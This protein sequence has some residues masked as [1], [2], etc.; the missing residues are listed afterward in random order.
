[1][2]ILDKMKKTKAEEKATETK[3]PVK[4]TKKAAPAKK[5]APK[6]TTTS[7]SVSKA[8]AVL[9]FPHISEKS[10]LKETKS[11]YTFVVT[12]DADKIS[13]KDAVETIYGVRPTKVRTMNMDGKSVRFGLKMGRRAD[14]KKA[15][16]TLP[17]GKSI[18]IHEG[19]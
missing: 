15:V 5:E 7:E 6:K 1:M 17:K 19:V 9:K 16:V 4:V 11:Q 18:N 12:A 2:G 14:W 8:H 10:A 3:A 13:I